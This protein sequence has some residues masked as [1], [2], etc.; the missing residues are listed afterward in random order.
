MA[1][2]LSVRDPELHRQADA[3][4][5][6]GGRAIAS[7]DDRG[8]A[9]RIERCR[10]AARGLPPA[11]GQFSLQL[12]DLA[13]LR[14]RVGWR[15]DALRLRAVGLIEAGLAH[16][17]GSADLCLDNG[18]ERLFVVR[19]AR[20]RRDI[21]RQAELLAAQVTAR[22]CGTIPGGAIIRVQTLP[23]DPDAALEGAV[24]RADLLARFEA[25]WHALDRDAP[26]PPGAPALQ[27]RYRPILHLRKRLVSAYRLIPDAGDGRTAAAIEAALGEEIDSWALRQ[28]VAMMLEQRHC[29]EPA[30]VV[31]VHYAT[32]AGIRPRELFTQACRQLPP[33]SSRQ[34]VFELLG[35]PP[36]LPQARVRELLGYLRPFCLALVV[37]LPYLTREIGH[38]TS[39]G[40]RGICLATAPGSGDERTPTPSIAALAGMARVAGMR[41]ML[42]DIATPPMC[43]AA[44]AAGIDHVSGD[45]LMPPLWRPGRAFVVA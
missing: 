30:L 25:A 12:F 7:P 4:A 1:L 26:I 8:V 45:G 24:S 17:L 2:N 21:E 20:E 29:R 22:L 37:R 34:L 5:P 10:A 35:L 38:L 11:E 14:A 40:A 44:A 43:R 23:F 3:G 31:P 36:E 18:G 27:P 15:W 16:A 9:V 42:V 6:P 41:S 13:R 32:L 33:R 19:A 28:A 39:S